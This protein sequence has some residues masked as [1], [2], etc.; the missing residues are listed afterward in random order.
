P[1]GPYA[2]TC[3]VGNGYLSQASEPEDAYRPFDARA[4]GYVPGEG[5]AILLVESRDR[6]GQRGAP[7]VYAEIAGYG[8]TQ[9][10]YHLGRPEPD[11]TQF[12]RA[13]TVALTAPGAFPDDVDA[14]FPAGFGVP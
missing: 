1:I 10:A 3:Q 7:Q 2:L 4:N 6:A 5:G 12:A 13:I 8:A 9:D 11:G 14:I